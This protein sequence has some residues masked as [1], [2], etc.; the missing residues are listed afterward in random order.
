[1]SRVL[2]I[3]AWDK[4]NK[5]FASFEENAINPNMDLWSVW[6]KSMTIRTD[7]TDG[8]LFE[9]FTGL[10]DTNGKEIYEG[11]ICKVEDWDTSDTDKIEYLGAVIFDE[12][13]LAFKLGHKTTKK[14]LSQHDMI[15]IIGNIH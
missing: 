10:H 1:M 3:R 15:T 9:Q 5:C 13:I 8:F 6:G 14:L 11:D 4:F 2:K 7:E 12:K